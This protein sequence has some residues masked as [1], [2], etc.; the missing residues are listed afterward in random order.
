MSSYSDSLPAAPLPHSELLLFKFCCVQRPP[1]SSSPLPAAL[2]APAPP[3]MPGKKRARPDGGKHAAAAK[4][5]R[6]DGEEEDDKATS[7]S[8]SSS[9]AAASSSSSSSSSSNS[10][11]SSSS[12]SALN[13]SAAAAAAAAAAAP[14]AGGGPTW[15]FVEEKGRRKKVYKGYRGIHVRLQNL[16]ATTDLRADLNLE[17]KTSFRGTKDLGC[18]VRSCTRKIRHGTNLG[19]I[20]SPQTKAPCAPANFTTAG[21]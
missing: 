4:R 20:L 13:S 11:S 5:N 6:K 15:W 8:S 3:A 14:S 7:S 18:Y 19:M 21:L 2:P 12:A 10:S 16:V 9:S 17:T 1:R